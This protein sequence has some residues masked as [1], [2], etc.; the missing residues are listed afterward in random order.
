MIETEKEFQTLE[1]I[2]YLE[3]TGERAK[4]RNSFPQANRGRLS[5]RFWNSLVFGNGP[6]A[7]HK[8]VIMNGIAKWS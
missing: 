2:R 6:I 5:C 4:S 7:R 3:G 1:R 8:Y